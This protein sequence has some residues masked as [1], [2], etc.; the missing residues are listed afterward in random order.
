M[1][2]ASEVRSRITPLV[3]KYALGD[4]FWWVFAP[5][6]VPTQ[7]GPRVVYTLI[8]HM[9]S[10]VIGETLSTISMIEN[11]LEL[12]EGS[13]LERHVA[14]LIEGLKSNRSEILAGES[15]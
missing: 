5:T 15:Q 10:P 14:A 4:I 11:P 2:L 3:D 12:V 6:V 7:S 13:D 9:R 1:D 8:M